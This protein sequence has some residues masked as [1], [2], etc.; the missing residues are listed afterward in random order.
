M[1]G[2]A[3]LDPWMLLLA[4]L[5]PLGLLV[6]RVRGAPAIRFG[7][8][9]LLGGRLPL[10]WR[11]LLLPLPRC[12]HVLGLLLVVLALAWPVHRVQLPL[13]K[14]GIDILLCLDVSSSMAAKDLDPQ[15]SRLDVAR[16]A[17]ARFIGDRPDDRIGVLR[18]ARY[19]DVLCPL[20]LDHRALAGFLGEIE[21]VEPDGPE[22]MTGIG[23]AVAR[24]AQLLRTSLATSKVVILLTD[25]EENVA[26]AQTPDEIGPGTAAA[27]CKELG[28]RAYTIVA[29]IGKRNRTGAWVPLDT[30]QV[31]H[32]AEATG[33][34]F[35]A[36][37]DAGA[38]AAVYRT[39]DE[40]E[41]VEFEEPRYELED[42][43]LP[44]LIAALA[45]M[46]AGR[47]LQSAWFEVLP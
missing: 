12:L 43:F 4:L 3:L 17:A 24:A 23:T 32:L 2:L 46:L 7:P 6:R 31:K 41:K 30:S 20:T 8:A 15:R 39:I 45:L 16:E 13:E 34:A 19:P 25:G 11:M 44:F 40:L 1:I 37:R 22:D 33:G 36:A 26:T 38:L 14:E 9:P 18:F 42:W 29:G 27:L 35:F 28:V 47:L 5:V 10:S 21:R